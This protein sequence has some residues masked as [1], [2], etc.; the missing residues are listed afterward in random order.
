MLFRLLLVAGLMSASAPAQGGPRRAAAAEKSA[1]MHLATADRAFRQ[2]AY[3]EALA[4]VQAAYAIDPRP[5]YLI[6]FAQVYRAMGDP[7][8][9]IQACELYLSTAPDGPHAHEARGLL[10]VARLELE[11]KRAA[12]APPATAPPTATAPPEASVP[13]ERAQSRVAAPTAPVPVEDRAPPPSR[14]RRRL[15]IGLAA[16][17][18]SVVVAGV[19]LGVGLGLGLPRGPQKI[20]FD[21]PRN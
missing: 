13:V 19:A 18:L 2:G 7:E 10:A 14:P 6:V 8:R 12:A 9:A 16:G 11:Q 21:P 20:S 15:A 5:D 3:D 4:E 1:R 17:G